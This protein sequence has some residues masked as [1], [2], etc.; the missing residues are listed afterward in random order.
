MTPQ[1]TT[2]RSKTRQTGT[3]RGILKLGEHTEYRIARLFVW[4]GY[5]VRRGRE[6]YTAG[7]LDQAT[8]LDVLA[9]KYS[10]LFSKEVITIESKTGGDGPLDRVFWLSG[11]RKFVGADRALLYRGS[12]TK[13]NI[14]DFAKESGVE[15]FDPI[16]L[17]ALEKR[18]V[19]EPELWL[20]ICDWDF[21]RERIV[22]WNKTLATHPKYKELY[23]TL[24]TEVRYNEPF[25]LIAFWIHH[26][27]GLVHDHA[28]EKD[29][30]QELVRFLIADA[31]GQLAVSFLNVAQSTVDL[32]AVERR[33]LV[34]KKL[35][36]GEEDPRLVER[37][38]HNSYQIAK[39]AIRDK[40]GADVEIERS[41]F[42]VPKPDYVSEIVDLIEELVSNSEQS[43]D[44]P[45]IA[46]IIMSEWFLKG[47]RNRRVLKRIFPYEGLAMRTA[48]AQRFLHRLRKL[49]AVPDVVDELFN[50]N[51]V[52]NHTD[53]R[54]PP[55]QQVSLKL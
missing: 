43:T 31:V 4:M 55:P 37:V 3:G 25:A 7:R 21:L 28:R 15:I 19:A 36:F 48:A 51:V 20:G 52:K 2:R 8:D 45:Q 14:K 40:L 38:F 24:V 53:T 10:A 17:S 13:W 30:V 33:G 54:K 11:L 47:N 23:Q 27:R 12:P 35:T 32:N 6:I 26:L 22:S 44:L 1:K 16:R 9:L 41:L 49:E 29:A 50:L 18:Y 39:A 42:A 34:E 5:F 46:D